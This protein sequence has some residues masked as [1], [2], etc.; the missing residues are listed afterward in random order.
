MTLAAI[1]DRRAG[2][3]YFGA[4]AVAG[5]LWWIG[6]ATVPAV[7]AAT[8]A[9]LP[10]GLIAVLD[11]PLFVIMSALAAAGLRGCAEAATGWTVLVTAAMAGYATLTGLAGW[12]AIA[13]I[14]ASAGSVAAL[15]LVRLG[16]LPSEWLMVGPFRARPRSSPCPMWPKR[17]PR[18]APPAARR[19]PRRGFSRA[20]RAGPR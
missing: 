2:R 9:G 3:L 15:L 14:A 7:R 17:G 18:P 13:M 16:H 8:L 19:V 11:I 20:C 1:L 6:V 5:A 12:G 4:Q 10:A